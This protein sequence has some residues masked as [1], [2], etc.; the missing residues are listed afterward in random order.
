MMRFPFYTIG[1]YAV[2]KNINTF[3]AYYPEQVN[4]IILYLYIQL[5]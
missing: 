1:I 2:N 5:L 4:K 3:L